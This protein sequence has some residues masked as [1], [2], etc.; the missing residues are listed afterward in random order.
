MNT[1]ETGKIFD[2]DSPD[3][4]DCPIFEAV[5]HLIWKMQNHPEPDLFIDRSVSDIMQDLQDAIDSKENETINQL[6][7]ARL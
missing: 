6:N 4:N 5:N 1:I 2:I 3:I 7:Q